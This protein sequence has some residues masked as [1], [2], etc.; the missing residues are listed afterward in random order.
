VIRLIQEAHAQRNGADTG[1]A[2][3]PD[4]EAEAVGG[5]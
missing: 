3:G 2:R 1:L 5:D 4:P